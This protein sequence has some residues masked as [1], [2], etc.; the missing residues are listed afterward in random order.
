MLI[1]AGPRPCPNS[2]T[3]QGDH[4]DEA[5]TE[6]HRADEGGERGGGDGQRGS[7]ELTGRHRQQSAHEQGARLDPGEHPA[8]HRREQQRDDLE[9]DE[10]QAGPERAEMR[11]GAEPDGDAVGGA[12]QPEPVRE[13]D[14]GARREGRDLQQVQVEHGQPNTNWPRWCCSARGREWTAAAGC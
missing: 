10:R 6:Q 7:P 5:D 2:R 3:R 14:D 11:H 1:T 13:G 8:E 4:A 9:D 12:D